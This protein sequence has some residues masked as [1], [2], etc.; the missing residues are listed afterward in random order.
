MV[1]E[2]TMGIR[3]LMGMQMQ[4]EIAKRMDRRNEMNSP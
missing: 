4:M 1:L 3:M 2:G